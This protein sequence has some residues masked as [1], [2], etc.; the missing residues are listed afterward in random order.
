MG[1]ERIDEQ[2]RDAVLAGLRML[3]AWKENRVTSK[4]AQHDVDIDMIETNGGEHDAL[5]AD[6]LETLCEEINTGSVTVLDKQ[7]VT[8]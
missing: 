1:T 8:A 7:A 2:R 6:E 3:Q 4:D 5:T